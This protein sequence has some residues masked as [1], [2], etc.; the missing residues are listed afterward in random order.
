MVYI[1]VG[2]A[3]LTSNLNMSPL[4]ASKNA[5]QLDA[6][7]SL[8]FSSVEVVKFQ[9]AKQGYTIPSLDSTAPHPLDSKLLGLDLKKAVQTIEGACA[10]LTA[11]VAPPAHTIINVC[12]HNWSCL[13]GSSCDSRQLQRSMGV[14][15]LFL[16]CSS[17][18]C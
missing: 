14:C 15:H 9:Y 2:A 3:F 11:I 16:A 12:K 5:T 17:L 10:Q 6:L 13:V 1:L 7:L 8:I 18:R 4:V